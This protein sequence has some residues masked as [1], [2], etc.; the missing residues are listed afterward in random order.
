MKVKLAKKGGGCKHQLD[1]SHISGLTQNI[2]VTLHKLTETASLRTVS[3]PYIAHLQ[4]LKRSRQLIG[5]VGVIS[6]KGYCQVIAKTGIYKIC[7]LFCL[8]K[9]QL[10]A[11]FEDF[12]DQL[13][14]VSA[15]LAAKV[16]NVLHA[17]S[18]D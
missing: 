8:V 17:R 3:S 7:L 9:L 15:L 5:V 13:L 1:L 14:I 11:S 12:E 18:L 16:L 6:G 2:N 4:C 10:L